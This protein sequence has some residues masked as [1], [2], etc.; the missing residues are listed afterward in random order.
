MIRN[1]AAILHAR[2]LDVDVPLPDPK[3]PDSGDILDKGGDATSWL[4]GRSSSFWT[5]VIILVVAAILTAAVKKSI[6]KGFLLGVVGLAILLIV[7]AG[8]R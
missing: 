4:A 1:L 5:I 6:V 2:V 8:G 3:A 7:F